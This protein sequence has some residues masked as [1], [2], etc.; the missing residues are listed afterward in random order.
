MTEAQAPGMQG[1]ARE[2]LERV[3]ID[4]VADHRPSARGEM[5]ANLMTAAGDGPAAHDR[6]IRRRVVRQ[7][8]EERHARRAVGPHDPPAAIGGIRAERQVDATA[9]RLDVA[10]DDSEI[11]L[12]RFGPDSL[13][14]P[15]RI[16]AA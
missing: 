8:L 3:A 13:Q 12:V 4:G 16:R 7:P 11:F 14:R 15:V 2:P 5:D 10:A 1:V 6:S 9:L